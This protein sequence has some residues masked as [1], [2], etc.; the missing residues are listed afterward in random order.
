M[1]ERNIK[2]NII[3]KSEEITGRDLIRLSNVV[4]QRLKV[5][6]YSENFSRGQKLDDLGYI[7]R[8]FNKYHLPG[9]YTLEEVE[10]FLEIS[11]KYYGDGK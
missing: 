5:R 2:Q 10:K 6:E 11:S 8:L 4:E 3:L 9:D 1:E 7:V